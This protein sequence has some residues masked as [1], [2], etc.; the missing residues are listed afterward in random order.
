MA[1]HAMSPMG[2]NGSVPF[3]VSAAIVVSRYAPPHLSGVHAPLLTLC[4]PGRPHVV[5]KHA[6][7][8]A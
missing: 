3:G 6:T 2:P 4:I 8:I 5:Q 1:P 7:L